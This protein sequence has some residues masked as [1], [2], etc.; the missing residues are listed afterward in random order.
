[1]GRVCPGNDLPCPADEAVLLRLYTL[2][3]QALRTLQQD[4]H[5]IWTMHNASVAQPH[6]HQLLFLW[7]LP[8]QHP[9]TAPSICCCLHAHTAD[10]LQEHE[11]SFRLQLIIDLLQVSRS[12][13]R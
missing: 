3:I 7:H 4:T 9:T 8:L 10:V 13:L 5:G 12:L 2:L 11:N 6:F 1:V